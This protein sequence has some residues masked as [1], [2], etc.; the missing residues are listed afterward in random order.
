MTYNA[1]VIQQILLFLNMFSSLFTTAMCLWV[2]GYVYVLDD[3]K[4]DLTAAGPVA[5][6]LSSYTLLWRPRV[7]LVRIPGWTW[8]PS[9][10]HVEVASHILQLEGPATKTY[11]YIVGGFGEKKQKEKK[12]EHWQQLLAQVPIFKRKMDLIFIK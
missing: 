8:H 3:F 6:W 2:W 9:S 11:N 5:E 10:D 1:Y 4:M 12:K 7:S